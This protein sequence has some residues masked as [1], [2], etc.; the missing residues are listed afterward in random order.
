MWYANHYPGLRTE[1]EIPYYQLDIEEVW[2]GWTWKGFFPTQQELLD[3]KLQI[4]KDTRFGTRVEAAEYDIE[5][6]GWVVSTSTGL[7]GRARFSP[8]LSR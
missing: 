2:R 8:T 4:S 6:D 1:N 7:V 5:S 3:E